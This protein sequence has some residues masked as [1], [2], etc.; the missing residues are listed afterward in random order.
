MD[1]SPRRRLVSSGVA[2]DELGIDRSTLAGWWAAGRVMPVFVTLGGHARWDMADLRRQI[3][4]WRARIR[5][6]G[7]DKL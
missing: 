7:E 5:D 4:E 2:A 6:L 1:R 3:E